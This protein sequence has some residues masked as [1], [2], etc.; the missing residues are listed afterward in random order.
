MTVWEKRR[1]F[2]LIELLV[3]FGIV[4][5]LTLVSVA[6]YNNFRAKEGVASVASE[7]VSKLRLA[8]ERATLVQK[9]NSLCEDLNYWYM[10]ATSTRPQVLS[11]GYNCDTNE[12]YSFG[13]IFSVPD[14][15]LVEGGLGFEI[16]FEPLTGV[17]MAGETTT[18]SVSSK[19][20]SGFLKQ[21]GVE[22]SGVINEL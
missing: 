19:I 5:V 7:I 4:A 9:P 6:F 20:N 11:V 14:D 17:N 16:H 10:R 18:I 22:S 15:V 13:D 3:V 21:I 12:S 2:S 8:R 1:A